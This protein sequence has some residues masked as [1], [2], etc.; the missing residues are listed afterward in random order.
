MNIRQIFGSV[1]ASWYLYGASIVALLGIAI[2]FVDYYID[3]RNPRFE[4]LVSEHSQ[5]LVWN[6]FIICG[7]SLLLSGIY[8]QKST[9]YGRVLVFIPALEIVICLYLTAPYWHRAFA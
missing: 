2:Q 7:L 8:Y 6:T 3:Y 4:Q 1:R 9:G 5:S